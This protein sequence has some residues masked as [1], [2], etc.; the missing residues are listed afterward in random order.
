MNA[1]EP[2]R[3]NKTLLSKGDAVHIDNLQILCDAYDYK[4]DM[5]PQEEFIND[6]I[7]KDFRQLLSPL[8]I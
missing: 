6:L 2:K 3:Q 4:K 7:H 8:S 5:P 1:K